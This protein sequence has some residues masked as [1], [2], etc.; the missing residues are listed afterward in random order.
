[1]EIN[2]ES[3]TITDDTIVSF[4]KENPHLDFVIMNRIFIDMINNLSTNLSDTVNTSVTSKILSLVTDIHSNLNNIKSDIIIKFHESKKEYIEDVKTVLHNNS[5][6]N[7][8]K[9]TTIMEKNNDNLL[10]KTTLIVNDVI[11]K[12][13]DKTYI[14]IENCIRSFCSSIAKDTERLLELN[15][16]DDSHIASVVQNIDKQFSSMITTIQQPIFSFIQSSEERTNSGIQQVKEHIFTQQTESQK[17]SGELNEFLNKYKNNSSSKGNISEAELYYMLQTIM[18]TDEIIKVGTDAATC[19]Y[20]VNRIDK[21]KPSILFENK[22][23]SRSAPTD[24]IKKFERDVQLQKIHGIFIS[25]K[26]PITYKNNF[27]IDIINGL[28]HIYI[29][30]AEYDTSKIK[31]AIDVIDSLSFKL[32]AIINSSD[33]ELSISK[34]DMED[35]IEEYKSFVTQKLQ[36]I[37]TIKL[38]TKQL[39]DKLE[40]IQL[41]KLK[42]LFIKM[43]NI[44]NDNDFKCTFCNSWSGKNKASLGAHI[45]NCKSNPKNKGVLE[46]S[47]EIAVVDEKCDQIDLNIQEPLSVSKKVKKSKHKSI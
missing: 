23:Y 46:I 10:A 2:D 27:Q 9:I 21:T 19:D 25:Q 17:L 29:P 43:G 35:I 32:D 16:K 44:E 40:D 12:S 24:E 11:P 1:M 31:L 4:Y 28:I 13:Q 18:P 8:E 39:I 36:M 37:D 22:D 15:N 5:L 42:K 26:S 33:D 47:T 20:K 41:P 14:Q 45:R 3:I 38:V 34:E 6:T 30:N 7:N